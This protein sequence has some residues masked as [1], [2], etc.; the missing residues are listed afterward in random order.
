[1]FFSISL[2]SSYEV[3]I[4]SNTVYN[5]TLSLLDF[6][7][8]ILISVSIPPTITSSNSVASIVEVAHFSVL[9]NKPRMPALGIFMHLEISC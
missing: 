9:R 1:M 5:D 8:S 4:L 2:K 7:G 3:G 6:N